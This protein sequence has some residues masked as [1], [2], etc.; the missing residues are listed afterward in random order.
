MLSAG[1]CSPAR[2]C[3]GLG[4]GSESAAS[5]AAH[6]QPAVTVDANFYLN[7][8]EQEFICNLFCHVSRLLA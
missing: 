5:S 4:A 7:A 3:L 2:V 1:L 6:H 8:A